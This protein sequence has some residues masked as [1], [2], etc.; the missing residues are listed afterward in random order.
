MVC[1]SDLVQ[2]E[3]MPLAVLVTPCGHIGSV[4]SSECGAV[5]VWMRCVRVL[6]LGEGVVSMRTVFE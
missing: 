5:F 4:C 6:L 2:E 1:S 3:L